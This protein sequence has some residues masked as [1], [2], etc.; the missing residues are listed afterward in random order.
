MRSCINACLPDAV[1]FASGQSCWTLYIKSMSYEY[2]SEFRLY[3]KRRLVYGGWNDKISYFIVSS[4]QHWHPKNIMSSRQNHLK[5]IEYNN[6]SIIL[7][8]RQY[9]VNTASDQFSGLCRVI[10]SWKWKLG[11]NARLT[12]KGDLANIHDPTKHLSPER[13]TANRQGAHSELASSK[14]LTALAPWV[15]SQGIC[16]RLW[17]FCLALR[18]SGS[19]LKEPNY[20]ERSEW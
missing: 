3:D 2:I 5:D 18:F 16:F 7:G 11:S 19:S 17:I 10:S 20:Y 13:A 9:L 15:C 6:S 14:E 12:S 4:G 1:H 8:I